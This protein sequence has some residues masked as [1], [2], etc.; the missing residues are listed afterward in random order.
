MAEGRAGD[1]SGSEAGGSEFRGDVAGG[2]DRRREPPVTN[3]AESE[4]DAGSG[5]QV[6]RT[7]RQVRSLKRETDKD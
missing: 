5:A 7:W 2:K 4:P 1:R 6:W 3:G